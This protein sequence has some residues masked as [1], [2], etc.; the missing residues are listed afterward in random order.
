MNPSVS[1]SFQFL[2]TTAPVHFQLLKHMKLVTLGQELLASATSSSFSLSI[3][4]SNFDLF[5][6]VTS[7]T[8]RTSTRTLAKRS[9]QDTNNT[10]LVPQRPNWLG[11][12][13]T[14]SK[15]VVSIDFNNLNRP[16]ELQNRPTFVGVTRHCSSSGPWPWPT[17]TDSAFLPES[18]RWRS[19]RALARK[20]ADSLLRI[21]C[22]LFSAFRTFLVLLFV[23][24]Y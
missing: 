10:V 13:V 6:R 2:C 9:R 20:V 21:Q 4:P 19:T 24:K 7:L 18:E 16:I 14:Q 1:E 5:P 15:Q 22:I 17:V 11:L 12:Q 23:S 8:K 3:T